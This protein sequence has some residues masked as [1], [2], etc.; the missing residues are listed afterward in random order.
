[1]S[2]KELKDM[3][4]EELESFRGDIDEMIKSKKDNTYNNKNIEEKIEHLN[5]YLDSIDFPSTYRFTERMILENNFYGIPVDLNVF[6][7]ETKS[8]FEYTCKSI[9]E[10][11]DALIKET[12]GNI[13]FS[14]I[15]YSLSTYFEYIINLNVVSNKKYIIHC[16][17]NDAGELY[18]TEINIVFKLCNGPY[19]DRDIEID[20]TDNDLYDE[21]YLIDWDKTPEKIINSI[22]KEIY[23][24]R[25]RLHEFINTNIR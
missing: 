3:T 9:F 2:N 19:F 21:V 12:G 25:E 6:E 14:N 15:E 7:I 17:E 1:M 4:L 24:F 20:V 13:F 23:N 8:F 18:V 10:M 11:I 22:N 5:N 16:K